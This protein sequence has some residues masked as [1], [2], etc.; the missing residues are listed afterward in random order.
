MRRREKFWNLIAWLKESSNKITILGV[1]KLNSD[2][3]ALQTAQ[4]LWETSLRT[5]IRDF[6][7]MK[8]TKKAFWLF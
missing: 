7:D 4:V 5:L 3:Y 6:W 1:G 2:K 8:Q